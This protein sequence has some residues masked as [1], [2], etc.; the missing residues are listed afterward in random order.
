VEA[1]LSGD[2]SVCWVGR[3]PLPTAVTSYL[4]QPFGYLREPGAEP[5]LVLVFCETPRRAWPHNEVEWTGAVSPP[6][7][8]SPALQALHRRFEKLIASMSAGDF[9]LPR[10][11]R[12]LMP[13][14]ALPLIKAE[15]FGDHAQAH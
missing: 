1:L 14:E 6:R 7:W 3:D 10:Y 9:T 4:M 11:F 15:Y 12:R 13:A 2:G 8:P 5:L